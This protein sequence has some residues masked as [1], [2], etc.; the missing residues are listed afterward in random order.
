MREITAIT[1]T[2]PTSVTEATATT[3]DTETPAITPVTEVPVTTPGTEITAIT[4][5]IAATATESATVRLTI[6]KEVNQTNRKRALIN[7]IL[8]TDTAV[9]FP[10]L[11]CYYDNTSVF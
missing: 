4:P 9:S 7:L 3:P 2:V 11:T 1:E 6:R 8:I 5:D 10:F